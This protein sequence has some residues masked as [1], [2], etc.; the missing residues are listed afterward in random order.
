MKLLS[1]NVAMFEANNESISDFLSKRNFDIV[2]LQ[3]VTEKIDASAD[4]IYISKNAIDSV[5]KDL[6]H[7]VFTPTLP[8]KEFHTKGFHQKE[9]FD[10]EFGGQINVGNYLKTRFKT[11]N[12]EIVMVKGYSEAKMASLL[13]FPENQIRSIQ[14]VDLE[15]PDNKKARIINYHGIWTKEKLGN[16]FTLSACRKIL[17]KAK[18]VNYPTIITGDFNLFPDTVSM[19]MFYKDFTSLVDKYHI[20]TTRP[21]HNEL[22]HLERN[23]VDYI[24]VSKNVKVNNFEV[25]ESTIS[26]HLPLI[27]DFEI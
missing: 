9:S 24:L 26:D 23:V 25:L 6:T 27:L 19:Q 10:F 13:S 18:E 15:L 20:S 1:L 21:N 5:T 12:E 14:I 2:C 16:E 17:E 4:P 22:S 7:S 11:I 8:L 3:E